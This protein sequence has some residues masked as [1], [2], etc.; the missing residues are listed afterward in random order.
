MCRFTAF[1]KSS[2]C[3]NVFEHKTIYRDIVIYH[4]NKKT[5]LIFSLIEC[6]SD[7]LIT[8]HEF[9]VLLRL[10]LKIIEQQ[11]LLHDLIEPL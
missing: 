11:S 7:E 6:T 1:L 5:Y 3:V 8:D 9:E 10:H 2:Y 4:N